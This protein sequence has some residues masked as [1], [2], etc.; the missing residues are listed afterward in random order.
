MSQSNYFNFN[1]RIA[2]YFVIL[3][4]LS[5]SPVRYWIYEIGNLSKG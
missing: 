4:V 2:L 1:A 5:G 3:C